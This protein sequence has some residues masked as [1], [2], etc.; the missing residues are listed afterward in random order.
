MLTKT[1][2]LTGDAPAPTCRLLLRSI[3]H[4]D[5]ISVGFPRLQRALVVDLRLQ[6]GDAP[7]TFVTENLF[8]HGREVAVIEERRTHL[9]PT[10][11][12]ASVAWGGATSA[13]VT[14]GILPAI[15]ARLGA[16]DRPDAIAAFAQLQE[17]EHTPNPLMIRARRANRPGTR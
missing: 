10:D 2:P 12:F 4:A 7:A 5:V 15:L 17:A 9:S 16:D 8:T 1:L 6:G 3:A 11:R 14:Q 13:F